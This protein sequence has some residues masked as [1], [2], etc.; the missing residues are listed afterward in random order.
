MQHFEIN[1]SSTSILD[2]PLRCESSFVL[3]ESC[4]LHVYMAC[5]IIFATGEQVIY[6]DLHKLSTTSVCTWWSCDRKQLKGKPRVRREFLIHFYVLLHWYLYTRWGIS[7]DKS[8]LVLIEGKHWITDQYLGTVHLATWFSVNISFHWASNIILRTQFWDPLFLA[9]RS[10]GILVTSG[11]QLRLENSYVWRTATS[12]DYVW[13]TATSG[14]QPRGGQPLLE[15][16]H[17][18]TANSH[19]WRTATSGEQS[20]P[21]SKNATSDSHIWN[22]H[23]WSSHVWRTTSLTNGHIRRIIVRRKSQLV[24]ILPVFPP[25]LIYLITMDSNAVL[26]LT[27]PQEEVC[28]APLKASMIWNL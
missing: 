15:N 1:T 9:N 8:F 21:E 18:R 2:P 16:S 24:R 12:G 19:V 13:R 25:R 7:P 22:G 5:S 11:E 10:W 20:R 28:E 3:E 14:E 27:Q 26:L 17:W 4:L 6:H 23:V